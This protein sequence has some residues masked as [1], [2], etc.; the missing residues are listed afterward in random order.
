MCQS[1]TGRLT[2][3]WFLPKPT[4]GLNTNGDGL[5]GIIR[6]KRLRLIRSTI[7]PV[8]LEEN[9]GKRQRRRPVSQ[10]RFESNTA[11]MQV[12]G[13]IATATSLVFKIK[14]NCCQIIFM[15][16]SFS[17]ITRNS[18]SFR[19]CCH[20]AVSNCLYSRPVCWCRRKQFAV[21]TPFSVPLFQT[22]LVLLLTFH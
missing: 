19:V 7:Q 10:Y 20:V 8:F 22:C 15:S 13:V 3:L 1:H 4:F 12:E 16:R 2:G 21:F 5:E 11:G 6:Y 14:K 9:H 18:Y 17:E